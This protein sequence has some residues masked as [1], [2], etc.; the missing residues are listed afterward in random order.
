MVRALYVMLGAGLLSCTESVDFDPPRGH[1]QLDPAVMFLAP[2]ETKQAIVRYF[3]E[4]G[5]QAHVDLAVAASSGIT[6]R[7]DSTFRQVYAADG[8]LMQF[9]D[10]TEQRLLVTLVEAVDQGTV[11][12]TGGEISSEL[13]V[14]RRP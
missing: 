9:P 6:A 10:L 3:Q 12:V 7:I 2:G 13:L 4:V 8:S 14:K 5:D 1:L 11:T